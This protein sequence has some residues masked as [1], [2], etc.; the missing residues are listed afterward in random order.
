M[1][2]QRT[3]LPLFPLGTTLFPG[4]PLP[5]HVFEPRYR[6][7]IEELLELPA[8]QPREFGVV[9]LRSGREAGELHDRSG[10][11]DIGTAAEIIDVQKLPD[12]RYVLRAMGGRR[13]RLHEV[14]TDPAGY[15]RGSVEWLPDTSDT[16]T[17]DEL[18]ALGA[19][20][21]RYL[22]MLGARRV[23]PSDEPTTRG[24]GDETDD[25]GADELDTDELDT[26]ELDTD[27][28]N[29]PTARGSR[30]SGDE[31]LPADPAER[32]GLVAT[33]GLMT[34]EDRQRLLALPSLA[35]LVRAEM[36][37]LRRELR[38]VEALHAVPA[39]IELL[40]ALVADFIAALPRPATG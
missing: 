36:V 33:V 32:A 10:L 31:V 8:D 7:M 18:G 5:L 35:A 22:S 29:D 1:P 19:L 30:G 39:T 16:P 34:F 28:V 12:G 25:D 40:E 27:D 3:S 13:F 20:F 15:L 9:S 21:E 14:D 37:W 24:G 23:V 11:A 2:T 26:D 6:L 4:V 17:S 38:L